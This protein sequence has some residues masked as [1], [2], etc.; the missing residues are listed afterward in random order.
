MN[1]KLGTH[2]LRMKGYYISPGQNGDKESQE[3]ILRVFF[4]KNLN[5]CVPNDV[6]LRSPSSQAF[7]KLFSK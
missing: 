4:Q 5:F 6:T 2:N 1:A 7:P 3:G